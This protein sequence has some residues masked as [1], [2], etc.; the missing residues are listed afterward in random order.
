MLRKK[1]Q[2]MG[3]VALVS[4]VLVF[5][6]YWTLRGGRMYGPA[7]LGMTLVP[8]AAAHFGKLDL[9]RLLPDV[10][11]GAIDTGLLTVAALI[12][13]ST[14]GIIGAVVGGVVGDAITDAIA[15]FFEGGISEWL[16]SKGIDESRTALGSA[17]G[18]MA[19]CLAGSGL[20]LTLAGL[21]GLAILE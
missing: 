19:G 2:E 14:F 4:L 18:K 10:I 12:G 21:I 9:R 7:V 11:F 13:A 15:G 16:R 20:V 5:L 3:V 6:A 8:L 17:C 1:G